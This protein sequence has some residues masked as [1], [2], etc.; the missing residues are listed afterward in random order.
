MTTALCS[1]KAQQQDQLS[2]LLQRSVR[3]LAAALA[4]ESHKFQQHQPHN[5]QIGQALFILAI[6]KNNQEAWAALYR[7]Y[8]PLVLTWIMQ[9]PEAS[10]IIA[11]EDGE[12]TSLINRA[13]AK[14]F[15]AVTPA[16][17]PRF[18]SLSALLKYL[19]LCAQ[20]AVGDEVRWYRAR[21]VEETIEEIDYELAVD[22]IADGVLATMSAHHLWQMI[23]DET[24]SDEERQVLY[25][26]FILGMKPR[27][28]S[29]DAP[30]LFPTAEYVCQVK[31]KVVDRLKRSRKLRPLALAS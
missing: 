11:Q 24:K 14:F 3:E 16:K 7:Q 6:T 22:D 8:R 31:R 19:Q 29:R 25:Q 5:D 15:Q 28:V 13:F 12:A 10:R 23:L 1:S 20:S 9:H 4:E 27:E 17:L 21:N 30:D 26:I 2:H 18:D